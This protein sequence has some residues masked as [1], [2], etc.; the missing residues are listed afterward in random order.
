[1]RFQK[2][3][4]KTT[5]FLELINEWLIANQKTTEIKRLCELGDCDTPR[6]ELP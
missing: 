4:R 5:K 1:M 2:T 3:S 6:V